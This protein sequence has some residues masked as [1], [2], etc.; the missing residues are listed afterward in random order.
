MKKSYRELIE[1]LC[2][3]EG[4]TEAYPVLLE[5]GAAAIPDVITGLTHSDPKIRKWCAAFFDHHAS[6]EAVPAII[7]ALDDPSAEVRR[8]AV[9]AIGCQRCK[10]DPL[11]VD[12]VAHLI[13]KATK[14]ESIRVRRSAVHLLGLQRNDPRI[15]AGLERI[16]NSET[17]EKLLSNARYAL[18]EQRKENR[19]DAR[20]E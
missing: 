8:H 20:R 16:L 14:D 19:R 3:P 11:P 1:M 12:V 2:T 13:R 4:W 7:R 15:A 17:D 10:L 5:A 6:K 18:A 9:H